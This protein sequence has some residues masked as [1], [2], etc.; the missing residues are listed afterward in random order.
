MIAFKVANTWNLTKKNKMVL[1]SWG[2][3]AQLYSIIVSSAMLV[4]SRIL[5]CERIIR[6]HDITYLL[7]QNH[8]VC[9]PYVS[10]VDSV[11]DHHQSSEF[12]PALVSGSPAEG[13]QQGAPPSTGPLQHLSAA[14]QKEARE[15]RGDHHLQVHTPQIIM[16]WGDRYNHEHW[17]WTFQKNVKYL[18]QHNVNW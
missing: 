13:C 14:V 15:W 1:F 10:Y 3:T 9:M 4:L 11:G 2:L 12:R 18:Y 7:F 6:S 5:C 8:Y 16:G 17:T